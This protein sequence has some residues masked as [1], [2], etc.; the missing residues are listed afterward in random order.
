VLFFC[1]TPQEVKR[2]SELFAF[3]HVRVWY[4]GWGLGGVLRDAERMK[5]A[6]EEGDGTRLKFSVFCVQTFLPANWWL[7]KTG[8]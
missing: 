3:F 6:S 8:I 4:V 2:S 7:F 1:Q 5:R